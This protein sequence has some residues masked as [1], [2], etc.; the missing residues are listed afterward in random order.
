MVP[1]IAPPGPASPARIAS[2]VRE[3][4]A[5]LPVVHRIALFGSLAEERAD[6][7]SDIDM[8]AVC[9]NP[10]AA[11]KAICSA[12]PIV[13]YRKF[14]AMEQPSGRY[15]FA[16]ESPLHRLDISFESV[17]GYQARLDNP[18]HEYTI[19]YREIYTS[20]TNP[21]TPDA[22][23]ALPFLQPASDHETRL[24][25][26]IFFSLRAIKH[27]LRTGVILENDIPRIAGLRDE[28][29]TLPRDTVMS[30][31]RIG[32]LAHQTADMLAHLG[33]I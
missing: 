29:P 5:G 24:G 2:E 13:F 17:E 10:W 23:D 18:P 15:Y 11:V 14:S 25:S 20:D 30:G 19:T 7:W 27:H 3:V 26:L 22:A 21:A 12:K 16:G 8:I 32:E 28:L 9:E 33:L 31:G 4:L 1:I 6:A